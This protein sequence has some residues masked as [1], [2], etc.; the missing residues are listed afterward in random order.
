MVNRY[1]SKTFILSMVCASIF[2]LSYNAIAK[3]VLRNTPAELTIEDILDCV[4]KHNF[5]DMKL[6]PEGQL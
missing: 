4:K 1:S 5:F 3:R 2:I 6:N